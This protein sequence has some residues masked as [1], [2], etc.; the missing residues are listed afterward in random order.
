MKKS[1][2]H[3]KLDNSLEETVKPLI[4]AKIEVNLLQFLSDLFKRLF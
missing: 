3:F 2:E 4:Y 1:S